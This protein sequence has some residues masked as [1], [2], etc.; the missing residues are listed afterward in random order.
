[1][2]TKSIKLCLFR[3]FFD[4]R[5]LIIREGRL[6]GGS[7]RWIAIYVVIDGWGNNEGILLLRG[8][9]GTHLSHASSSLTISPSL[10]LSE[11]DQSS[12]NHT[13]I[14]PDKLMLDRA[15]MYHWFEAPDSNKYYLFGLH[16]FHR[17]AERICLPKGACRRLGY[18]YPS[19]SWFFGEL[20]PS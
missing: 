14:K 6:V 16:R 8:V 1:M 13:F 18:S 12:N 5:M 3:H 11:G 9:C 7:H 4:C 19:L 17:L 20:K 15:V 2:G 10:G